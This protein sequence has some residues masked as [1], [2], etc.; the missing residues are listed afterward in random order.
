MGKVQTCI[1]VCLLVLSAHLPAQSTATWLPKNPLYF[2]QGF[3]P[4]N[5]NKLVA[6]MGSLTIK[7]GGNQLFDPNILNV[8]LST[9]VSTQVF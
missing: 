4:L 9:S 5:T 8:N 6:H 7:P 2:E 3:S 1:V